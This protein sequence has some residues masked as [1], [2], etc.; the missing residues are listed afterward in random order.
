MMLIHYGPSRAEH[1]RPLHPGGLA[2]VRPCACL[3]NKRVDCL[4]GKPGV[5]LQN[6]KPADVIS[7]LRS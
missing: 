3:K 2:D 4:A 7:W 5:C 1:W 6:I